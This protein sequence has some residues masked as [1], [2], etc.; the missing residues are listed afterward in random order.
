MR[1]PLRRTLGWLGLPLTI[2]RPNSSE[3]SARLNYWQVVNTS[4]L[5]FFSPTLKPTI[6][7]P[8]HLVFHLYIECVVFSC[9]TSTSSPHHPSVFRGEPAVCF[10]SPAGEGLQLPGWLFPPTA[11]HSGLSGTLTVHDD[12]VNIALVLMLLYLISVVLIKQFLN[13][14]FDLQPFKS[15]MYKNKVT[16]SKYSHL[17][18]PT[19]EHMFFVLM[20]RLLQQT[21]WISLSCG[22]L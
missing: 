18:F 19:N 1:V 2:Q 11:H 20:D 12:Q 22:N 15:S 4:W 13:T 17:N 5:M 9:V 8:L 6:H 14:K 7:H 3:R 16:N 10:S 21:K